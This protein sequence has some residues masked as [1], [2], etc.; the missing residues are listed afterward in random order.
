MAPAR[1]R[2]APVRVPLHH[3][4]ALLRP[5]A[6]PRPQGVRRHASAGRD[7]ATGSAL[8]APVAPHDRSRNS[9]PGAG[10]R[11]GGAAGARGRRRRDRDRRVQ[12][13]R[14]APVP[15]GRDQ[16]SRR[17]LQRRSPRACQADAGGPAGGARH[18]RPRFLRLDEIER[19]GRT[20][21]LCRAVRPQNRKYAGRYDAAVAL[22]RRCRSRCDSRLAGR[23]VSAPDGAGGPAAYRRHMCT[24]RSST[25]ARARG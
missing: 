10:L 4:A 9:R 12:R 1:A 25:R 22:A 13:L 6:R 7:R 15:V 24:R 23:L 18:S 19:E 5:P 20:Q 8:W 3:P 14:P 16:R 2:S 11:A 17:R 21:R